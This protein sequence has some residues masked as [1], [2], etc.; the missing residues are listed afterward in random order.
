MVFVPDHPAQRT[1]LAPGVVVPPLASAHFITHQQH[2]YATGQQQGAEQI[3]LLPSSQCQP[4]WLGGGSFDAVVPAVVVVVAVAVV[5]AVGQ[6]VLAVLTHPVG[7]GE[8]IVGRDEVHGVANGYG[9]AVVEVWT[10]L[11]ALG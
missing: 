10:A 9:L 7:K 5:F 11:K 6:V 2:R 3:A 8:A 4:R 1:V